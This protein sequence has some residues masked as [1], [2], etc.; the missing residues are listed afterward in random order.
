MKARTAAQRELDAGYCFFLVA[1]FLTESLAAVVAALSNA[2]M[3]VVAKYWV[4]GNEMDS[5]G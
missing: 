1:V 4:F 5:H 3:A 2:L